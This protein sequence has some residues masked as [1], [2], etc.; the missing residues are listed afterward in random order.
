MR[1]TNLVGTAMLRYVIG[2]GPLAEVSVDEAVRMIA[3]SVRR[4]LTA[5]ADELGLPDSY[6][7]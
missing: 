7:P 1:S 6:R 3:P 2:V 5:D 4:Y